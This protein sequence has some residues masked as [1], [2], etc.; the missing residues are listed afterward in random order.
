MVDVLNDSGGREQLL[1]LGARTV[2]V[3]AKGDTFVFGQLL[4]SIA[5]FLGTAGTGQHKLPPEHLVPR[6]RVILEAARRLVAQVPSER[7]SERVIPNRD[8]SIRL[9]CHHMFRIAESFIEAWDGA[10]YTVQSANVP[11]ADDIQMPQQIIAY[12]DTVRARFDAWWKRVEDKSCRKTLDTFLGPCPAHDLLERST[13]HTAQHCRQ[14]ADV[15][16]GFGIT[17]DRPLTQE[18]LAGLPL[19]AR[20]YE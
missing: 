9:L 17:P 8:R 20:L 11:P 6:Y 12:G 10:E 4:E 1:T 18:Q 5:E 15:P 2:P 19:P 7:K 16:E 13:W 14:L 3:V